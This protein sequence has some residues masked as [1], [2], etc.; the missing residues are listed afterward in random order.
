MNASEILKGLIATAYKQSRKDDDINQPLSVQPWGQDGRRRRYWLIEGQND[1]SFRVYRQSPSKI[2]RETWWSVAGSLDELKNFAEKLR[3]DDGSQAARRLADKMDLAVPR[4]EATDEVRPMLA[5]ECL[6]RNGTD[7]SNQQKRRRKEYRQNRKAIFTRPEPGFSLYEGR[8]RGKRMKYTFSEDE[9]DGSD[10]ASFRRSN[11]HSNRSTPADL[12]GP[13]ITSSGRQVRSRFGRSYGEPITSDRQ[14][15]VDPLQNDH[16]ES[17]RVPR[18]RFREG[19]SV[20]DETSDEEDIPS[21]DDWQGDDEDIDDN[22]DDYDDMSDVV[23]DEG[24]SPRRSSLVVTLKYK[25]PPAKGQIEND[26]N[27]DRTLGDQPPEVAAGSSS[28]IQNGRSHFQVAPVS[29]AEDRQE[30]LVPKPDWLH[31]SHAPGS[32]DNLATKNGQI[33]LGSDFEPQNGLDSSGNLQVS[34]QAIHEIPATPRLS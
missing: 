21:G 10:S 31:R 22:E 27:G 15:S 14:G 7:T 2:V 16:G 8:T 18:G 9:D 30:A 34:T 33:P 26:V 4:L 19:H 24:L 6:F 20:D 29:D 1:T 13:T 17:V 25:S 23:S 3:S 5:L 11:R 28:G 12:A 32:A